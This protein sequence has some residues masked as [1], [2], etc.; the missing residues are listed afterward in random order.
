MCYMFLFLHGVQ[1]TGYADDIT[2]FLVKDNLTDVIS[3]LEQVG[4]K[5]LI[6]FF[7]NWMKFNNDKCHLLWNTPKQNIPNIRNFT[8]ENL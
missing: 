2:Y 4:E 8:I 5:L 7:H 6:W 1:S 3:A